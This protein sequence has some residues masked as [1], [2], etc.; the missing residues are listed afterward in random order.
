MTDTDLDAGE[1]MSLDEL[2]SSQLK[3]LKTTVTSVYEKVPFYRKAFD[4]LGVT[5]ADI[6]SLEDIAKLPFTNKQDLRDN[7]PFGM[8]AVP[9]QLVGL[10]AR[11]RPHAR[12]GPAR[13]RAAL[14]GADLLL[15]SHGWLRR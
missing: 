9:Q 3:N 15:L 6:T 2:R 13:P 5:P 7:Y 10:E 1:R 12:P 8:F 11:L 14:R 4:D